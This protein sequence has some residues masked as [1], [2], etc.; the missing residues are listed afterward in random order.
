MENEGKII[1]LLA[2]SL[3]R[4]DKMVDKQNQMVTEQQQMVSMQNQMVLKQTLMV[5]EQQETNRRLGNLEVRA[6]KHDKRFESVEKNLISLNLQTVENTRAIFKLADS[7]DK[8]GGF[9]DR[10][11]KIEKILFK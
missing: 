3:K 4:F 7:V 1:E 8:F 2:E 6:D 10:L 11:V 5:A 9:N